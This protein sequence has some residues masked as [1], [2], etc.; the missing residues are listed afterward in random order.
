ML[1]YFLKRLLTLIPSF[2]GLTVLVYFLSSLAGGSPLEMILQD[3]FISPEEVARKAAELG[4]DKPVYVQYWNWLKELMQGN[5]G[6]SY[7]TFQPVSEMIAEA[8]GPTLILTGTSTLLALLFSVPL[9]LMAGYKPYSKWDYVSSAIS[10]FGAS[11]PNF[12]AA[13]SLIY[14]F[15]ISIGILPSSGMYPA[16]GARTWGAF[17]KHLILPA[18][19][20]A[21]QQVGSLIR[22]TRGSVVEVLQ[23]D[24]IRTARAQGISQR[25]ILWQYGLRNALA[26]IIT[27]LGMQLPFIVGGAV[28]TEQIFSWP[29]L[30]SMMVRAINARDYLVIMGV[31]VFITTGVFIGNFIIDIV[32]GLIDPR[33]RHKG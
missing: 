26:P 3:P 25:R 14:I 31:T 10:Y 23:S 17:F 1:K 29:G 16:Y 4:L 11:M 13:L 21:I 32:Y 15:S 6:V 22:Q 7:R 27:V 33:V 9:G 2:I 8:V 28:V 20:L 18:V 5:L 12:F 30:G 24:Y 19:V